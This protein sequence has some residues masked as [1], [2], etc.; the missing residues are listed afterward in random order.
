MDYVAKHNYSYPPAATPPIMDI[1]MDD[2]ASLDEYF[3]NYVPLSNLPTPPPSSISN[4]PPALQLYSDTDAQL[5]SKPAHK[6]ASL[7]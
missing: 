1:D 7:P 3:D 4:S 6:T 2:D 5:L